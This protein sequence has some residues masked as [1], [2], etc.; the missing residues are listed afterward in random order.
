[1]FP[2]HKFCVRDMF[3]SLA[4]MKTELISFQCLSLIEK[5]CFL[6]KASVLTTMKMAECEEIQAGH[7]QRK[8][9]LLSQSLSAPFFQRIPSPLSSKRVIAIHK[10]AICLPFCRRHL[11]RSNA[12]FTVT[13]IVWS[14]G[15][16]KCEHPSP[17]FLGSQFIHRRMR[18]SFAFRNNVIV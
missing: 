7:A 1:M 8:A 2:G 4:T 10:A 11:K 9:I 15:D 12:M 17:G 14:P 3:P 13:C 5:K 18:R 6:T 16:E